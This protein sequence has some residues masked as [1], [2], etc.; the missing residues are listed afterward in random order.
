MDGWYIK[1]VGIQPPEHPHGT[2]VRDA[3][4]LRVPAYFE[5][6]EAPRY[7]LRLLELL[8]FSPYYNASHF[9]AECF[10]PTTSPLYTERQGGPEQCIVSL[11]Q[12][13]YIK[14]YNISTVVAN[15][16][17]NFYGTNGVRYATVGE[18]STLM[19]VRNLRVHVGWC[20]AGGGAGCA[21]DTC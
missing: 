9:V 15:V 16:D 11:A 2:V 20:C 17:P 14:T 21:N 5:D 8:S 12:Q 18:G 19:V 3:P 6:R 10:A 4:N 7:I 1:E 13:V